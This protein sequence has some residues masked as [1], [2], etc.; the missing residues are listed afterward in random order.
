[1]C[2]MHAMNEINVDDMNKQFNISI[3][4]AVYLLDDRICLIKQQFSTQIK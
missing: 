2:Y 4:T 1:V 3:S